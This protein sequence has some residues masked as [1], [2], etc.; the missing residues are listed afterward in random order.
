[1]DFYVNPSVFSSAFAFPNDVA[2]KYLKLCKGEHIKVL[3]YIM[4]NGADKV[5]E[6]KIALETDITV[7]EV[8]EAI[9]FWADTGILVCNNTA[10]E[11]EKTATVKKALRP[12]RDDVTKRG[13]EDEK[14]NYLLNQTQMIFGRGL[15][16][17]ELETLGWLYDDLGLDASVIL[18]IVQYA[19]LNKKANIRFIESLATD[20]VDKGV[21]TIVDAE[22]QVRLI[23]LSQQAWGI[24]CAAFGI[25]RRNPSKK[26]N[27]LAL[28]WISEWKIS[29]EMLKCA[30]DAC[31]D[32]KSKFS[33]PYVAKIIENWHNNGYKTPNDIKQKE[34]NNGTATYNI[35]LFEKM[36][37]SK[38]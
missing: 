11:T 4:R 26:E 19:K 25:E 31:V 38:E 22:E 21:E 33:F 2:D 14:L 23:T 15:K 10:K 6:E 16:G 35:D 28:K 18:Y 17:N 3:I 7:Y 12:T 34:L 8:K 30:Y 1:M 37:D 24:V 9:L 13:L 36:L 20:W 27:E 32:A 29:K 5:T